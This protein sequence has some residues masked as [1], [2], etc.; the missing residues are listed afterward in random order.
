MND[1]L[2]NVLSE[3]AIKLGTSVEHLWKVLVYQAKINVVI[4]SIWYFLIISIG[5][6]LFKLHV[7]FEKK[8]E[9]STTRYSPSSYY[10]DQEA[11]GY[12]MGILACVWLVS[13]VMAFFSLGDFISAVF[14]P[15]YWALNE[16]LHK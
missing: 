10:E 2:Q 7:R 6:I 15:E 3:L 4:D 5:V 8:I 14:N 1:K 9:H 11:S 13:S 12:I 16:I